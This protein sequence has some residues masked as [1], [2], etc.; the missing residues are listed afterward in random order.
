V[1]AISNF[2]NT[3]SATI[4]I[5]LKEAAGDGRLKTGDKVMLVAFGVG[6]SWGAT[7]IQWRG[8]LI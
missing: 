1:I 5:A 8:G 7:L 6:Y 3:V 2:G 4:P